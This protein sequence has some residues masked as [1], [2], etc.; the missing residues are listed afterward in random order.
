[1]SVFVCGVFFPVLLQCL[2]NVLK[3]PANYDPIRKDLEFH[4]KYLR[5]PPISGVHVGEHQEVFSCERYSKPI[6]LT[7]SFSSL[8]SPRIVEFCRDGS[9][10]ECNRSAWSLA[11]SI[12]KHHPLALDAWIGMDVMRKLVNLI[13]TQSPS[14]V[15]INGLEFLTKFLWLGEKARSKYRTNSKPFVE[16]RKRFQR[17]M[18]TFC[19]FLLER[20]LFVQI[21]MVYEKSSDG[22][23]GMCF[24]RCVTLYQ[25]IATLDDSAELYAELRKVWFRSSTFSIEDSDCVSVCL[26]MYQC[27]NGYQW[28]LSCIRN[29]NMR[30]HSL[31]FL[32]ITLRERA[33]LSASHS[34]HGNDN[35]PSTSVPSRKSNSQ[36]AKDRK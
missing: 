32:R 26:L 5:F 28:V 29:Q 13:Q 35:D 24:Q 12:L 1:L 33:L 8:S 34:N 11:L 36:R 23:K 10:F 3:I 25:A 15:N 27:I 4:D 30:K 18:T 14:I 17:F 20:T 31:T 7:I 21:H 6:I 22:N 2:K 16:Q 9:D 19:S